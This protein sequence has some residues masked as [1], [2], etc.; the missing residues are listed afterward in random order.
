MLT[1][2]T[3]SDA[4]ETLAAVLAFVDSFGAG[5]EE[6]ER[7]GQT[8]KQESGPSARVEATQRRRKT[9][10]QQLQ[11]LRLTATA[12][13][14]TLSDL[15]TTQGDHKESTTREDNAGPSTGLTGA[16][17]GVAQSQRTQHDEVQ[18]ENAMLRKL[19]SEQLKFSRDFNRLLHRKRNCAEALLSED[20]DDA[21]RAKP[22]V[23]SE[24]IRSTELKDELLAVLDEL[25]EDVDRI[26]ADARYHQ[27]KPLEPLRVV[28]LRNDGS[29]GL[30]IECL[31]GYVL[32][33]DHHQAA[34]VLWDVLRSD[35]EARIWVVR[36]HSV[37]DNITTDIAEGV[38]E[39]P[40][41]STIV[42]IKTVSRLYTQPNRTVL[43]GTSA[44]EVHRLNGKDVD[45]IRTQM[46]V[47]HIL[48]PMVRD[49]A[50]ATPPP[51]RWR[52]LHRISPFKMEKHGPSR[53]LVDQAT[54]Y[55]ARGIQHNLDTRSQQ[56][57]NRLL[58]Q[59]RGLQL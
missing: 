48:E 54:Q 31:G 50:S 39:G 26:F 57:E 33:F 35:K 51:T 32:P 45:N 43:V 10:K 22:V 58:D 34:D 13:E 36:E 1:M 24:W 14:N 59:M 5:E 12:L 30:S 53:K 20:S 38:I 44:M 41:R 17:E 28:E 40:N 27:Q 15:K 42:Q 37:E 16:W 47:W 4:E 18:A 46:C 52:S 19:I 49:T 11:E 2:A 23:T 55:I 25:F 7:D 56:L 29:T 9:A 3:T 6:L 8:Q 21:K